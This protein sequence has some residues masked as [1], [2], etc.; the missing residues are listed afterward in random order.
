MPLS[1]AF[2]SGPLFPGRLVKRGKV[3]D[4][5]Q[6]GPDRLLFVASDRISAFDVVLDPGVPGK[7]VVLTQLSNFWFGTL[8]GVVPNHLLATILSDFPE[9]FSKEASLAGRACVVKALRI[10]PVECVVRGFIVGSGWKEYQAKGSV[11]GVRLPSGLRQAERLPE[12][13]FTPSTKEEVGHDENIPFDEVVRLAGGNVAE[14]L[15]DVSLE[16]YRLAASLAEKRGIIIADTKFEFGLDVD[17]GVVWADEALTPDSSRF[18]PADVYRPGSNPPSFDKQF[19]RD[20][21]EASGWNKTPPAPELPD[22]VVRKTSAKY[23][24][25]YEKLTGKKFPR[26]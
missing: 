6:V 17:G 24:E 8:G 1:A 18:W 11:C 21:L 9:P 15:R 14:R 26:G 7:G 5:Y 12:P 25:A 19:V 22:E 20:W 2:S 13:I 23:I 3:R 4:V 16:I 10:I